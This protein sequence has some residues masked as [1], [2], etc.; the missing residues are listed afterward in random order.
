MEMTCTEG[1]RGRGVGSMGRA[2]RS[3]EEK[4]M[5]GRRVRFAGKRRVKS[6]MRRYTGTEAKKNSREE[7]RG[8]NVIR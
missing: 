6:K 4:Q 7:R 2:G 8:G 5:T 3:E 1:A